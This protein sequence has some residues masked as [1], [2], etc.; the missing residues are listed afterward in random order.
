MKQDKR[1]DSQWSTDKLA[2]RHF[3]ATDESSRPLAQ[4]L[5][6]KLTLAR[7]AVPERISQEKSN[8]TGDEGS[9]VVGR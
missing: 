3:P 2:I 4:K 6:E 1:I 8:L 9:H 7:T 5:A